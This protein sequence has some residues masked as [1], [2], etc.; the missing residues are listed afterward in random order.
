MNRL[1]L[2]FEKK[3]ITIE[4]DNQKSIEWSDDLQEKKSAIYKLLGF[5]TV[6]IT[7]AVKTLEDMLNGKI[8][9][10]EMYSKLAKWIEE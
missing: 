3:Q 5:E 10:E 1:I 7:P 9:E 6:N 8:S 2:D 4:T